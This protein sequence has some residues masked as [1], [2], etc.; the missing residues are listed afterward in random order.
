MRLTIEPNIINCGDQTNHLIIMLY[1]QPI[2]YYSGDYARQSTLYGRRQG[3][4]TLYNLP[5]TLKTRLHT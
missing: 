1:R 2:P 3:A 5:G 4:P